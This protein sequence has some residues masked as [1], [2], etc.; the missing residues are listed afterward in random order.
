MKKLLLF[1]LLFL[2]N[3]GEKSTSI[4][5][6]SYYD[7]STDDILDNTLYSNSIDSLAGLF[8]IDEN[9]DTNWEQSTLQSA[10]FFFNITIDGIPVDAEDWVFAF[11]NNICV[12]SRLWDT[13]LCGNGVCEIVL[14][15]DDQF[16]W[17]GG[18]MNSGDIPTFKIYDAS[19][20]L[21]YDA[22][23]S[24]EYGWQNFGF[25]LIS[26]LNGY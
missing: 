4:P 5:L 18:Y 26:D 19:E 24:E 3:C 22:I 25:F 12:G 11:N 20:D 9:L 14:M 15:G 17:T 6:Y 10:Y 23:P 1:L 8:A 16:S 21:Y 7:E 2:F 13:S